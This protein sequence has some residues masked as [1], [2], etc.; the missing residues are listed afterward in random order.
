MH[1]FAVAGS[2]ARSFLERIRRVLGE[3]GYDD[4]AS[5]RIDDGELVVRFSRLGTSE[6]RFAIRERE[7]GFVADFLGAR[8]AP[9][10][11]PFRSAFEGRFE[12]VLD[13]VGAH[14]LEG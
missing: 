14:L 11:A 8:V 5:V 2:N 7:N 13:R 12:E 9:L 6:L 3:R 4:I 10:H 1:S